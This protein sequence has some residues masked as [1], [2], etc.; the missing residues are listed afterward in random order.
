M[1]M[2]K[3]SGRA[4]ATQRAVIGGVQQLQPVRPFLLVFPGQI[5]AC[6]V[7]TPIGLVIV[8]P[9]TFDELFMSLDHIPGGRED[10][11]AAPDGS[12]HGCDQAKFGRSPLS[13]ANLRC[14]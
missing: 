1:P 7:L 4:E 3:L 14:K 11:I 6:K 8:G 10:G 9:Y 2:A 12:I 13:M 5:H